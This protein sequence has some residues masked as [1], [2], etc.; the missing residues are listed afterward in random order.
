[1][2]IR[3]FT[4]H[5]PATLTQACEL[6]RALAGEVRYLAGGTDLLVDLR[7]KRDTAEHLISLRDVPDL[8]Y[9]H[10]DGDVLRIGALATLA[11]VGAS[12]AVHE[13]FPALGEAVLTVGS[14][15]VRELGTIGGNFCRAVPC[16]DSPPV[17]IAGQAQVTIAGTADERTVDAEA[18]FVGARETVLAPGEI[19][20]E[21]RIPRQPPMSGASYQRFS[22]RRGAALAVA[23]VAVR[24]VLDGERIAE[25]RPVLGAVAPVPLFAEECAGML[26]G[27]VPSEEL[28][29]RAAQAAAGEA[30]PIT[31]LRGS[32]EFRRD[33]VEVLTV[34]ALREAVVRAGGAPA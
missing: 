28:F 15:Q 33:L 18:F 20:T 5:R 4:Y 13:M 22:L 12:P 11:D 17:C 31:D 30:Q 23:A 32:E 3:G 21:I 25:A 27:Q 14:V 1:M 6:G 2:G 7:Q 10:T 16:A 34:R 8:T 24:V 29:A 26:G 19:L 9:I